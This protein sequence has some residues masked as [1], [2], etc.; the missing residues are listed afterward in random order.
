MEMIFARSGGFAGAAT[1]VEGKVTFAGTSARVTAGPSYERELSENETRELR[2]SMMQVCARVIGNDQCI[3]F[4]GATGGQFQLNIMMPVMGLA[5]INSVTLLA[6]ATSAV[7]T[8][9][10][11][12]GKDITGDSEAR[13]GM[14]QREGIS[15]HRRHTPKPAPVRCLRAKHHG[16]EPQRSPSEQDQTRVFPIQPMLPGG[17][18]GRDLPYIFPDRLLNS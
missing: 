5:A 6:S 3:A 12:R 7:T 1:D 4:S 13:E 15:I 18:T 10:S 17:H 14:G 9:R 2:E 16:G 11:E 8:N